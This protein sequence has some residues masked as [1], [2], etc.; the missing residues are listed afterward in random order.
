VKRGEWSAGVMENGDRYFSTY[1][2]MQSVGPC[3][4]YAGDPDGSR[5][6]SNYYVEHL[7]VCTR[8]EFSRLARP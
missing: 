5:F 8:Y 4:R 7:I 3:A 2:K 1:F 6:G